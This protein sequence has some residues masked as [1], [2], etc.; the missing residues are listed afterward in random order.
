MDDI[1]VF[2][3]DI[4]K[5]EKDADVTQFAFETINNFEEMKN[6]IKDFKAGKKD[7]RAGFASAY[8][9]IYDS[10]GKTGDYQLLA[11]ASTRA[12]EEKLKKLKQAILQRNTDECF[13]DYQ[14]I[15][16]VIMLNR[17]SES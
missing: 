15:N 13:Y 14:K 4:L 1:R 3:E 7:D 8:K 5:T 6:H 16:D 17:L 11:A 12:D 2:S 9:Q 10:M